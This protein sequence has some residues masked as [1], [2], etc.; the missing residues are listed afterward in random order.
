MKIN[1]LAAAVCIVIV[2]L[3]FTAVADN[4]YLILYR[5]RLLFYYFLAT[6]LHL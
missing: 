6:V 2:T 1:A 4:W 3:T 5:I